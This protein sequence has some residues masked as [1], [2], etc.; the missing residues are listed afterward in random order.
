MSGRDRCYAL[1]ELQQWES[2]RA[3]HYVW[4]DPAAI[5]S[6]GRAL[7][8]AG[9]ALAT[10]AESL[11]GIA[12]GDFWT[13]PAA[14]AFT[15]LTGRVAP[16]VRGLAGMHQAAAAALGTWQ[17]HL[18]VHQEDCAAAVGTGKQGWQLY[19]A[20]SCDNAEARNK[21]TA[22]RN[23]IST[24][25]ASAT[26]AGRTCGAA[27]EAAAARADV[28]TAPPAGGPGQ[29]HQVSSTPGQVG[30]APSGQEPVPAPV[31]YAPGQY[32]DPANGRLVH[33]VPGPWAIGRQPWEYAD[34]SAAPAPFA[35]PAT[36]PAPA[37]PADLG[38]SPSGQ[39]PVPFTGPVPAGGPP[40]HV[41]PTNGREV[42][43]LQGPYPTGQ[44]PWVYQ[45]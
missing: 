17:R 12:V 35:Q 16:A 20:T 15:E 27:L 7:D 18:A 34:G 23:A 39:P 14:T 44:R 4:G 29:P 42:V 32:V 26:G 25:Q 3:D 31:P 11:G 40:H 2:A 1:P 10:I 8:T 22:G 45:D 9:G 21:M 30:R 43:P 33:P 13:G 41:D 38:V 6:Y 36:Q 19:Q 5:E 28:P 24:A 37:P